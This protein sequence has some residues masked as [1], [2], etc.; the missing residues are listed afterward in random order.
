M[1]PPA[2]THHFSNER[3]RIQSIDHATLVDMFLALDT[4]FQQLADYVRDIV[5]QKYGSKNERFA[6][7]GQL[8]LFPGQTVA[9]AEPQATQQTVPAKKADKIKRPGH[10]RNP[11]PDHL[12]RVPIIAPE[13]L[14]SELPCP[15]C[16]TM[17][18]ATRQI[19]Q[20]R[21]YQFVPASFFIEDLYAVVYVCPNGHD[22]EQLIVR[23]PEIVENGIAGSGLLAQVAVARDFDHQ[24]FNRQSTIYARSG[25]K[26]SRSTL[27]DFYAHLAEI[28]TPLYLLMHQILLQSRIIST[29][30]TPVKVLDRSKEKN[31][32]TGRKWAYLGD[33]EHPVN[34]LDY[35][36]GRG[37]DGPLK[38]LRGFAGILQGD[39]FSGNLAVCAA[40][41]TT[42]VAC[43]AHARRYFIKAILNN[44]DGCNQALSMFQALY[45]IERTATELDL[46][47]EE[48]RL[49]R[50]QESVPV[51]ES[52][53]RWLQ[54][55]YASAQPKSSFGKALFYCLNNW[56]ELKQYVTDGELKI[57]NNHCEREMKYTGMGKRNWLFFGS[58]QGGKNH[59]IVGSVLST[60]RRHGV[61]P[62]AYLN[63]VIQRLTENPHTNLEE[64]LPYNWKPRSESSQT[65]EITVAKDAPKVASGSLKIENA[66]AIG[67]FKTAK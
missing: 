66:H 34:V 59:A 60:C 48:I 58:D 52:L 23:V 33:K 9:N 29:D 50:E 32:K 55:Q 53:H 2:T 12:I 15:C 8:L 62:W 18:V 6:S 65:A 51:L 46:P 21:R 57:D 25:V 14:L 41:G 17:R 24:P 22:S 26:L 7:P 30:D 40:I 64:L 61:E 49:M 67:S 11:M 44:R 4:K 56:D 35:T 28:L 19:L 16:R 27:S 31:I 38:F 10:A 36:E 3:E 63:D 54:S 47:T 5:A 1:Q 20:N 45:E 39:C 37:R 42:L 43:L 13:P